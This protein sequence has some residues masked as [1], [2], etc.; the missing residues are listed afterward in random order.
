[1]GITDFAQEQLGEIVY[2]E[3][4]TIGDLLDKD[5]AFATVEAVKTTSDIYMPVDGEVIEL[6]E[7]LDEEGEN[8]PTLVNSDPY[9]EGWIARIK[10]KDPAQLE[11]LLS[12]QKYP[13]QTPKKPS[14]ASAFW[15]E[16]R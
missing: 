7:K 16:A 13:A 3:V 2:V 9:G 6:N 14:T 15:I 1:V 11:E 8:E 10:V 5:E 4:E 12:V